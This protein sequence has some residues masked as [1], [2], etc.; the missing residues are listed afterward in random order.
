MSWAI[1]ACEKGQQWQRALQLL[2]ATQADGVELDVISYNAAISACEKRQGGGLRMRTVIC[3]GL[4][5]FLVAWFS[6]ARGGKG[7]IN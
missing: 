4:C 3:T 2:E 1:S 6:L 5:L 7:G